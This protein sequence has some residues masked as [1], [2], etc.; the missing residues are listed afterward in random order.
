MEQGSKKPCRSNETL[1]KKKKK[2]EVE[3]SI[4]RTIY[5]MSCDE[6]LEYAKHILQDA[7]E[8][9]QQLNMKSESSDS[10]T[11]TTDDGDAGNGG[12]YGHGEVSHNDNGNTGLMEDGSCKHGYLRDNCGY[13]WDDEN[14]PESIKVDDN[15]D[16]TCK[17]QKNKPI[18]EKMRD[19]DNLFRPKLNTQNM[20]D[21]IEREWDELDSGKK[22]SPAK[23]KCKE[24]VRSTRTRS[25][26]DDITEKNVGTLPDTVP[27]NSLY[28][29]NPNYDDAPANL[30]TD[31][32]ALPVSQLDAHFSKQTKET[33][34]CVS[35]V[36]DTIPVH[37]P[38]FHIDSPQHETRVS[39][40]QPRGT[41]PSILDELMSDDPSPRSHELPKSCGTYSI[42]DE[43]I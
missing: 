32:T 4:K 9:N 19:M 39:E 36:T 18:W 2:N 26:A 35:S 40:Y 37:M 5:C 16:N 21:K 28:H 34:H 30:S 38:Q 33:L 41:T 17:V 20:I 23:T 8:D 14:E 11:D 24:T 27:Y 31:S 15:V 1:V 22:H 25:A 43:L 42:L 6:V 29:H 3:D 10:E 7:G 13:C 12:I